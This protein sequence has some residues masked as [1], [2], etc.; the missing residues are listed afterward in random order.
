MLPVS[1]PDGY[2]W[3]HTQDRMWRKTRSRSGTGWDLVCRGT[4]PNRNFGFHWNEAGASSHPCSDIYAGRQ[5]FSEPETKAMSE[6]IMKIRDQAIAY[7]SLH[8]Y[9]QLIL[10]PWGWTKD[11]P[12]AYPDQERVALSAATALNSM[13]HTQYKIGSSTNVLY[14]AAGGSD[15]WAH[16]TA[17]IKYSYTI[18]LRDTGDHGFVLPKEQIV[19]TG[20]ETFAAILDMAHNFGIERGL[21]PER[22]NKM[23]S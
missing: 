11:L 16:G 22:E 19:E 13:Y 18:E 21:Y 2:E 14:A 17:G 23:R 6:Y 8:S 20:D 4:D 10:T 12:D 1:N 7:I 15:D 9:S 5:A 3:T